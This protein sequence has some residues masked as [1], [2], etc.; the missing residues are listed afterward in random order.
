MKYMK[1]FEQFI[2]EAKKAD[3]PFPGKKGDLIKLKEDTYFQTPELRN[4]KL[5]AGTKLEYNGFYNQYHWFIR[6]DSKKKDNQVCTSYPPDKNEFEKI[7]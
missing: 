6:V 7:K 4:I 1:T 2:N 3:N 5:P